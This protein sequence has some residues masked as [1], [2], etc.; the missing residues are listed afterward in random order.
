MYTVLLTRGQ[1]T[2]SK[3][4]SVQV[5][6]RSP[7]I[8]LADALNSLLRLS[9]LNTISVSGTDIVVKECYVPA[10]SI[11]PEGLSGECVRLMTWWL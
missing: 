8:L 4:V 1:S 6:L 10:Y 9:W 2:K 7:S 5:S 3:N 11:P